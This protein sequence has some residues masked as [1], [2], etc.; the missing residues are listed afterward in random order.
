MHKILM[1]EISDDPIVAAG[2]FKNDDGTMRQSKP[3]QK[4]YL[5]TGA[6]YPTQF[7]L[8]IQDG[9]SP[10]RPGMYFLSGDC[11]KSGQ[12]G[13]ELV[14]SRVTLVPVADAVAALTA[15]GPRS[16]KAA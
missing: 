11:F 16:V 9:T 14:W 8:T 6:R 15:D 7:Q 2:S 1:V 12:Y 4:A 3:K 10:L 5:H 13:P